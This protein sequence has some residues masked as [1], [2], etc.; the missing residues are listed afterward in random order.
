MVCHNT[1]DTKLHC[2]YQFAV[3][4]KGQIYIPFI[5]YLL[6]GLCIILILTFK[7]SA[8]LTKAYGLAVV[9]D[10][11]LTTHFASLV[12]VLSASETCIPWPSPSSHLTEPNIKP[13]Q[14]CQLLVLVVL[15]VWWLFSWTSDIVLIAV[16]DTAFSVQGSN[17]LYQASSA[18]RSCNKKGRNTQDTMV[19]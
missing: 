13:T 9:I 18:A 4:H 3:Q 8:Q 1:L 10:M 16:Q 17:I 11:F 14:L 6:G 2:T 15:V 19:C 7:T 12:R 5:C